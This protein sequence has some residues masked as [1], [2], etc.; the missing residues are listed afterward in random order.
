ML[1]TGTADD[2]LLSSGRGDVQQDTCRQRSLPLLSFREV[3]VKAEKHCH[4]RATT[5]S[6]Q[7]CRS[8]KP[9]PEHSQPLR[10]RSS[11]RQG[12]CQRSGGI[13]FF[14]ER[15]VCFFFI[16]SIFRTVWV[17]SRL[18]PETSNTRAANRLGY[19]GSLCLGTAVEMMQF[20]SALPFSSVAMTESFIASMPIVPISAG[21]MPSATS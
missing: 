11:S 1:V 5:F 6:L 18:R 21:S 3:R 2:L 12:S 7:R 17:E 19:L 10:H 13:L 9:M 20:I 4:L 14:E 8:S 16:H 15:Q